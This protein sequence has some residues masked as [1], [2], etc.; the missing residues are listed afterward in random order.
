MINDFDVLKL[1]NLRIFELRDLARQVGVK[2][3]TIFRKEDLIDEMLLIISG[4]NEPYVNKNNLGRP[5]KTNHNIITD[6][7]FVSKQ[8]AEDEYTKNFE[9]FAFFV[10]SPEISYNSG[11]NETIESGYLDI[12]KD[13]YGIVRV[14]GFLQSTEDVFLHSSA[15]AEFNLKTGDFI[16][17]KT[18]TYSKSKPKVMFKVLKVNNNKPKEISRLDFETLPY[19]NLTNP[20]RINNSKFNFLEGS[21]N[22]IFTNNNFICSTTIQSLISSID[23][24]YKI[25]VVNF[26][27]KPEEK[28]YSENN[29]EFVCIYFNKGENEKLSAANL[30]IEK[31]KRDVENGEKVVFLINLS[32]SL[33]RAVNILYGE[34]NYLNKET[35]QRI[36]NLLM[37]AK[38]VNE[39]TSFSLICCESLN[40]ESY[41]KDFILYDLGNIFNSTVYL[42]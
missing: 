1:K 6:E 42:E 26:D 7:L 11:E 3:P 34:G 18:K 10:N 24:S 41:I 25:F 39:K 30:I 17:G 21:R 23:K 19:N 33:I 37:C 16:E 20:L 14:N 8:G 13:G 22:F 5:A 35:V 15:L 38:Y 4:K 29:L 32:S 28:S 2:S 9:N 40:L 12:S 36:K 31:A 27:A